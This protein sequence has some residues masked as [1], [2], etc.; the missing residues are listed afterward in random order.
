M[1]VSLTV[2]RS[3]QAGKKAL[4]IPLPC[5]LVDT[6]EQL[7]AALQNDDQ[8]DPATIATIRDH[9]AFARGL[10]P[11]PSSSDSTRGEIAETK[12]SAQ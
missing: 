7:E 8:V 11:V 5:D 12:Q 2:Y 1:A 10:A 4:E 9:V 3:E 6:L